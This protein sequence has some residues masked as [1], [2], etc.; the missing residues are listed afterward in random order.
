MECLLSSQA[1][2]KRDDLLKEVGSR[3]PAGKGR[4]Q[5]KSGWGGAPWQC[6]QET[7]SQYPGHTERKE[8]DR[9]SNHHTENWDSAA[10]S[11]TA[12]CA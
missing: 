8:S 1:I 5:S 11:V 12:G 9:D 10:K 3:F 6:G 4:D 7:E 2:R